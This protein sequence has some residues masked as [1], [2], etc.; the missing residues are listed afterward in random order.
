VLLS[1]EFV[2]HVV[3]DPGCEQVAGIPIRKYWN[4]FTPHAGTAG[5]TDAK[6]AY[7]ALRFVNVAASITPSRGDIGR[8][9]ARKAATLLAENI[10]RGD[11]VN[12]G[13]GLPE[14]V[15]GIFCDAGLAGEV[16]FSVESGALGGIPSPGLFFGSA[17]YPQELESSRE[18]FE[19][20]RRGLPAAVLGFLQIDAAGNVN[21]S[22]RG[23][24]VT[25]IIGPGGFIDICEAAQTII[26]VGN[27][28]VR[29]KTIVENQQVKIMG[30]G[31]P[32]FVPLLDQVTFSAARALK[33]GKRV[34]YVTDF[35][36]LRLSE[37]GLILASVFPGINKKEDIERSLPIHVAGMA[38]AA[39]IS[40]EIVTGE[41]FRLS[42]SD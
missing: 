1:G 38:D 6:R 35:G 37:Q 3:L 19:R 24:D 9:L 10:R 16:L 32:K 8:V 15:A 2:D 39:T 14:E 21:V 11:L 23:S 25:G 30:H 31:Q 17:I 5:T 40:C 20:Y 4:I 12:I 33:A 26:F 18:T 41:N 13:V 29:G 34:Y 28:M 42:I 27:W 36:I 7:A 22:R